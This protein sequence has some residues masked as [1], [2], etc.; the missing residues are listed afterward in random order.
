MYLKQHSL[1]IWPGYLTSVRLMEDGILMGVE[2][3]HKVLRRDTAMDVM[4]RIRQQGG[5]FQVLCNFFKILIHNQLK[6]NLMV[7]FFY[8]SLKSKLSWR[9]RWSWPTTTRELTELTTSTLRW[10]QCQPST[11]T[12]KIETLLMWSFIGRDTKWRWE[13]SLSLCWCLVLHFKYKA[14]KRK[15]W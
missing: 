5:D 15:I 11:C 8:F 1:T 12:K 3:I 9:V 7:F 14:F 4:N 13:M 2:T 10:T 6:S